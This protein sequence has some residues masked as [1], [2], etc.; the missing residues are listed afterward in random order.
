MMSSKNITPSED[1]LYNVLESIYFLHRVGDHQ[2]AYALAKE[3]SKE[4]KEN[5]TLSAL[6]QLI[7]FIGKYEQNK[8]GAL[9]YAEL[10]N[11]L[12]ETIENCDIPFYKG[13]LHFL[14]GHHVKKMDELKLAASFFAAGDHVKELYEVYYW[15]NNF[16][17]LPEEEKYSSLLRLYPIKSI[18][19]KIMGNPFY[20]DELSPL[21]QIQKDQAKIWLVD[22]EDMPFDC[23]LISGNAITP[24]TYSKLNL[25]DEN[26]LDIYSGLINDRGE[27]LFL[28]ISELNCFSFLISSQLI[29]ATVAQVAEFLGNTEAEAESTIQSVIKMGIKAKKV[30][31]KYFLNWEAKPQII[32]PRTLKV[33]GLQE[34]IR[35]KVSNFTKIQL[36][37][38][39]QVT[40]FGAE[41]LI[42]KWATAGFIKQVDQNENSNVWKFV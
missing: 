35:K 30:K 9:D 31:D 16:R 37:D 28:N 4:I 38:I 33:L 20:K 27:F 2:E 5:P 7:N 3:S 18:Y 13:W 32:V 19:S 6:A 42:K 34:F 24:A 40:P 22:D 23:W 39:L 36:I 12:L 8:F 10:A 1:K 21:T 25:G 15:T 17:L 26:V 41:S 11:A 14:L 29:G